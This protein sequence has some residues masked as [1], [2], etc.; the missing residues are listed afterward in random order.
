MIIMDK[1]K[2]FDHTNN[3]FIDLEADGCE[4]FEW[5]QFCGKAKF[6]RHPKGFKVFLPPDRLL[7][8]NEYADSDPYNVEKNINSEFS[9]RRIDLTIYLLEKAISSVQGIPKILDLGCGQ[10]HITQAMHQAYS[11]AEF[12]GL[13]YSVSAIEYAHDNF[14]GIDF[15]VGDAYDAPYVKE[16]FDIVVCNNLWEHVP[17]PLRLLSKIK[18]LLKPGGYIVISTP[19]RYRVYNILRILIGKPVKL[20]SKYHV[21]EYSVGQ[22]VEQ[23][24]YGCFQVMAILSK[25]I[26]GSMKFRVV[27]KLFSTWVSIVGSHHQL[28]DTVFYLA[29]NLQN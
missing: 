5:D 22:I 12:T 10:G 27:R 17:D 3:C 24:S 26:S 7:I 15:S 11:F 16:Y 28:E 14:S 20:I 25:P 19:S 9:K 4:L 23:L 6:A 13:D 8:N 21:T 29:R 1:S 18:I 2:Y